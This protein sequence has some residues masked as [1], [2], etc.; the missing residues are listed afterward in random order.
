M[1]RLKR[2][3][4]DIVRLVQESIRALQKTDSIRVS[5]LAGLAD[6]GLLADEELIRKVLV[7]L[8]TNAVEAMPAGGDL[9]VVIDGE[10]DEVVI[11]IEDT[12]VG[13]SRENMDRLFT[14][15][16]TTKPAGEGTG[17]GLPA[18]YG[19]VKAH[20]GTIAIESNADPQS[21]PTGTKVRIALSRR[22]LQ[23]ESA[24]RMVLHEE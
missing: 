13:I 1:Q 5:V 17:L 9:R 10:R 16:F 11:A 24:W 7:D 8:M 21:G 22:P 23:P 6:P 18:A 15:F 4:T 12:G 20:S 3:E 14:P 2:R 19:A